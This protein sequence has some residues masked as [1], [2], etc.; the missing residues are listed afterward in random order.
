MLRVGVI[1]TGAIGLEHI[2][3]FDIIDEACVVAVAD[4]NAQSLQWAAEALGDR[5]GD[6]KFY[7]HYNELLA[8][9]NVDAVIICTPNFHHIHVIRAAVPSGKH[10]LCE[11]PMCTTMADC[12]EVERLLEGY[13]GVFWVGMEYRYIPSVRR[14]ISEV[15]RK[16]IGKLRMLSIREHRFPFLKKVGDWNRFSA[17]T[18]GTLVEKCCHFFD[19][20]ARITQ[21][22]PLRVMASGAQDLNHLK[23]NYCGNIPDILDNAYVVIDWDDGSRSCL[24]LCMF[25]EASIN[26]EEICA[27]GDAGKIEA[28]APAHGAKPKGA[29]ADGRADSKQL[30][31]LIIGRRSSSTWEGDRVRPPDPDTMP[32]L[33]MVH[34]TADQRILDAG[35]HMGA[36]YF[37]LKAFIGAVQEG[38]EPEVGVQDG[39]LAVAM[40]VAAHKSIDEGRVVEMSEVLQDVREGASAAGSRSDRYRMAGRTVYGVCML[41]AVAVVAGIAMSL[42]KQR[43]QM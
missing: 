16:T 29:N 39:L 40:G 32:P 6:C 3:N 34:E 43:V 4:N 5:S 38:K 12:R 2:R 41:A 27:V 30:P 28:F 21:A 19:L 13:Q 20:M 1:G 26:Q 24:D 8:D 35:F 11:K 42:T 37:E 7:S 36:T 10:I 18:G 31:N 15:E 23:E 22:K 14:L 17:N 33:E 9:D 25:A